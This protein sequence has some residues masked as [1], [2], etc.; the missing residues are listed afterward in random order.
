MA[1]WLVCHGHCNA[2]IRVWKL[3]RMW[4]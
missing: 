2:A 1:Y 4:K 3:F